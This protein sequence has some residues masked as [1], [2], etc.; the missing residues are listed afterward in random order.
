MK[1]G[2]GGPRQPFG[3]GDG[4]VEVR[5]LQAWGK[6]TGNLSWKT[7]GEAEGA[8]QWVSTLV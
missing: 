3:V 1:W 2:G 8:Q 6:G 5:G 4:A 7:G